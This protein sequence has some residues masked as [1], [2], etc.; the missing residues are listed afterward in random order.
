V[1]E[2]IEKLLSEDVPREHITYRKVGRKELGYVTGRYCKQRLNEIFGWDG[3][4]YTVVEQKI[5]T[6][7][8][9][10]VRWFAH[11]ALS[12]NTEDGCVERHGLA[13]GHGVLQ[14]E[15]WEGGRSTGKFES[16]SVGRANEVI[17][18]AAAE[19]VTD[20]LKRA[21]VSLGQNLGLSLY[22]Y[23]KGDKDDHK[24]DAP[25]PAPVDE[26]KAIDRLVSSIAGATTEAA[27]ALVG[28]AVKDSG[29][30]GKALN[31]LR[32]LYEAKL[33]ELKM[34]EMPPP[35]DPEEK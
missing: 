30:S 22:P 21:A 19:A 4:T 16:V 9:H 26:K 6:L 32:S 24:D 2:S 33:M 23:A 17:D 12:V 7:D 13:V 11:V 18:F 29:L 31:G 35:A 1:T 10:C 34:E 3:W 14:K 8:E 15:I 5:I 20:A 25:K 28:K 27:L